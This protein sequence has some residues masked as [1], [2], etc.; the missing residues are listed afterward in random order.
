MAL[1]TANRRLSMISLD[2]SWGRVLPLPD[3]SVNDGDRVQGVGKYRGFYDG[4]VPP[5]LLSPFK[6]VIR[7]RR[8]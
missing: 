1:D 6:P 2:L 5:P 4:G 7:P 3:G 8:R